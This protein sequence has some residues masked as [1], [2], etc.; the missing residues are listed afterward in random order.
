[1]VRPQRKHNAGVA[2]DLSVLQGGR[3]FRPRPS[4]RKEERKL[5]QEAEFRLVPVL[6][7]H[8]L[9]ARLLVCRRTFHRTTFFIF[10]LS[11]AFHLCFCPTLNAPENRQQLLQRVLGFCHQSGNNHQSLE[12]RIW[13]ICREQ[14]RVIQQHS[15]KITQVVRKVSEFGQVFTRNRN[16]SERGHFGLTHR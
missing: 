12:H 6:E 2:S 14:R 16:G 10:C 7:L 15:H 4:C 5:R 11:A 3:Q 1:M 9:R 8:G 13:E